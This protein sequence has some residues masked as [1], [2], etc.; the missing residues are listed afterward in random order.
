MKCAMLGLKVLK[1]AALGKIASGRTKRPDGVRCRRFAFAIPLRRAGVRRVDVGTRAAPARWPA[2]S[3]RGLRS[4]RRLLTGLLR[5]GI[6]RGAARVG[7]RRS[8]CGDPSLRASPSSRR[9]CDRGAAVESGWIGEDL[10][11]A[12]RR[13]RTAHRDG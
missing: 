10:R 12:L 6:G 5:F 11:R 13:R 3:S 7:D 1:S 2:T 4:P 8:R 9:G